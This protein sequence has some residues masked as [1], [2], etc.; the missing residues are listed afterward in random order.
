MRYVLS[1]KTSKLPIQQ[2]PF[3]GPLIY[4]KAGQLVPDTIRHTFLLLFLHIFIYNAVRTCGA[5]IK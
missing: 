2:Q 4:D 5:E 1:S 3:Y